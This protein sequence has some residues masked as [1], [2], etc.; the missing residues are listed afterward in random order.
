MIGNKLN[1]NKSF[2]Y[3][4]IDRVEFKSNII[5]LIFI[6]ISLFSAALLFNG[7]G[8]SSVGAVVTGNLIDDKEI[9][10]NPTMV[11][12]TIE[13]SGMAFSS[14]SS[15]VLYSAQ[16]P[17]YSEDFRSNYQILLADINGVAMPLNFGVFVSQNSFI[18][19][20]PLPSSARQ[21]MILLKHKSG[22]I[23]YKS[24]VG[25]IPAMSEV[26][27]NSIK[28]SNI[29]IN[30]ETTAKSLFFLENK[31]K[32]PD[33]Y[34]ALSDTADTT[35]FEISANQVVNDAD[36]SKFVNAIKA[37]H[38]TIIKT[39]SFNSDKLMYIKSNFL[40]NLTSLL[41][42]YI[43]LAKIYET[44]SSLRQVI[45]F[46]TPTTQVFGITIN[47]NTSTI[48]I[49]EVVNKINEISPSTV[50]MLSYISLSK[51]IDT[52]SSAAAYNLGLITANAFYSD[53]TSNSVVVSWSVTSGGGSLIG[54]TYH[55]PVGPSISVLNAS[56]T[57]NL[58][59]KSKVLTLNINAPVVTSTLVISEQKVTISA[60]GNYIV[61]WKTNIPTALKAKI[62]IMSSSV[63]NPADVIFNESLSV[64][65]F[66]H[67]YI[68]SATS[69]LS[70]FYG[71]KISY[72]IIDSQ[73]EDIGTFVIVEKKNFV[74]DS[75]TIVISSSAVVKN[76]S[77]DYIV[78]WKTNIPTSIKAKLTI[79]SSEVPNAADIIVIEPQSGV[80]DH[81][82]TL[83]STIMPASFSGIRI[84]YLILNSSGEDIGIFKDVKYEPIA[85]NIIIS[86]AAVVKNAGGDYIVTWKTNILTLEKA[87][88]TIMSSEV[89]NA[90]D[91]IVVE[92]QSGVIDHSVTLS[93]TIM[94]ASFSAIRI[95]YLIL[96]SSGEDIGTYKDV[97][98]EPTV[99]SI[100]I[101][102]AMAVKNAG[103]DYTVTWKT[104]SATSVKAKIT[105]MS[106]IIPSAVD[107]IIVES[108]SGVL[109]HSV[110]LASSIMPASFY[111]IRISYLIIDSS[112]EDV[113]TYK[114]II[115]TSIQ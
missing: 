2:F 20:A 6:Y 102:S 36:G 21:A 42:S 28:V 110:N 83:S 93:S 84:S 100:V 104:N 109:D 73:G 22:Y 90:D 60:S 47:K 41:N 80:I 76:N 82:V 72:L 51:N 88:L 34:L 97:K 77:G 74:F 37:Q 53:G 31:S 107:K 9:I 65:D 18:I 4:I 108:Q 71:I 92:P 75:Q 103:G 39:L 111:A 95:S 85:E 24:I 15:P 33:K 44:D 23:A 112:G 59:T 30:D 8:G 63:L 40:S 49:V 67:E 32:I 70:D 101:S 26:A 89:P 12:K 87:K 29:K 98:Y 62:T 10:T 64:A 25:K 113:G 115:K 68:I 96:N 17:S 11:T 55:A 61:S 69:V 45:G 57:E 81:S 94:P 1:T 5:S 27:T 54:S 86:S 79:M 19:S 78:T 35:D 52:L 16:Q 105:I 99:E 106:S 48:A 66:S 114:D 13:I 14:V 58:I 7:C 50:K 43:E 56:Y 91:K 38:S 46:I 3:K